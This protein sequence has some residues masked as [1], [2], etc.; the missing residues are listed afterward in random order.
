MVISAL[1]G[2]VAFVA[3]LLSLFGNSSSQSGDTK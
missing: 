2:A 3:W 1:V